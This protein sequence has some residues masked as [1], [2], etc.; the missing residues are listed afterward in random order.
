M[1]QAESL[2]NAKKLAHKG[3]E[4]MGS[5]DYEGAIEYFTKAIVSNNIKEKQQ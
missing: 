3:E 4:L 5:K 2:L 1:F